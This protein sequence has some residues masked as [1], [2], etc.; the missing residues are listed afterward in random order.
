[1]DRNILNWFQELFKS[2]G[3]GISNVFQKFIVWV[4]NLGLSLSSIQIKIIALILLLGGLYCIIKFLSWSKKF[5]KI[6]IIILFSIL[7]VSILFS[8]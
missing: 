1:M 3:E 7:I 4:S 2:I 6:G 5:L 8:L